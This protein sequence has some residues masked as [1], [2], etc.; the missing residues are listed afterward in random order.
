[1]HD[2][3]AAQQSSRSRS[4]ERPGLSEELRAL[5]AIAH[6]ANRSLSLDDILRVALD[7]I[8]LLTRAQAGRLCLWERAGA[9]PT[10]LA[11]QGA[12]IGQDER[13]QMAHLLPD[14]ECAFAQHGDIVRADLAADKA[15]EMLPSALRQAGYRSMLLM[16]LRL[17]GEVRGVLA[18]AGDAPDQFAGADE[19]LLWALA[20]QVSL[21]LDDA[22][23]YR[24]TLAQ[25]RR[26]RS[27]LEGLSDGYALLQDDRLVY[28]NTCLGQMFGEPPAALLGRSLASLLAPDEVPAD[29]PCG[30]L[31][32]WLPG[33]P[34]RTCVRRADGSV[35]PVE[36]VL[37][38]IDLEGQPAAAVTCRDLSYQAKLETQLVQA[39]KLSAVGQL[40][41]GVAHELNNPLTTIKGYA[42]LLPGEGV[43]PAVAADLKRVEDAADRCR[44]IVGD[45]LAFARR[46]EP[47]R[48]DTDLNDLLQ[49][50]LALRSYELD[51]RDI[52][53]VWDL[54]P[55]L[56]CISVDTHRLQQVILN[57]V[58]NAEQAIM[59]KE[60]PKGVITIRTR[61]NAEA[62]W[63]RFQVVDDGPGIHPEHMERIFEA[64]FTTKE[65]GVGTGLGLSISRGIVQDHGGRIRAE[66][67][68][69]AGATFTVELPM[70]RNQDAWSSGRVP[71]KQSDSDA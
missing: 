54:D 45:L 32:G 7:Q 52:K 18:V 56:P 66:S 2:A 59:S 17:R 38:P 19:T 60:E 63:G 41:A 53:L 67:T 30:D 22:C 29:A 69:G 5:Q 15:S 61:H 65:V 14:L 48:D 68:P 1:M 21:A 49:R 9:Q 62:G 16:A 13:E 34:W 71:E 57:L 10:C 39:A 44:R 37:K 47:E 46:Y 23:L 27:Q 28:A 4:T 31:H 70:Q 3:E 50:T 26:Y 24:Q 12:C 33:S 43:S 64:F 55:E 8:A 36:L 35:L 42:Q 25:E 6:A 51:V 58:F 20:E 40:V 11:T